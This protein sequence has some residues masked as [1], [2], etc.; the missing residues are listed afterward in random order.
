MLVGCVAGLPVQTETPSEHFDTDYVETH[1]GSTKEEVLQKLGAPDAIF[2]AK[3][4]TYYVYEAAGD[5][6]GVFGLVVVVPPFF[7]PFWTPK[8][9]GEALHCLGLVFDDKGYLQDYLTET[10]PEAAGVGF[11]PG[12]G[13]PVEVF[14]TEEV[15]G[16]VKTLWTYEERQSLELVYPRNMSEEAKWFCPQADDGIADSQ[17]RIGDLLYYGYGERRSGDLV[18]AY[19]W[20]SLSA[21]GNNSVAQMRLAAV[22]KELTHEDL[23]E[24][25]QRLD[26]W[27]PRHGQCMKD[28][29]EAGLL[30][31]AEQQY[32]RYVALSPNDPTRLPYL[33]RAADGGHPNAQIE[34]GR[35]FAQGI[36]GLT[37]DLRRAYVWYSLAN[38]SFPDLV[39]LQSVI[40][41]MSPEQIAEAEQMLVS[42]KPGQ[43]ARELLGAGESLE[44]E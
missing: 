34:V 16:C 18:G 14:S 10:A 30:D 4:R 19:V 26:A 6:R 1:V 27:K 31:G 24:A 9:E 35:H 3:G 23:R 44:A 22:E 41:Q 28:L 21:M 38:R 17:R 15:T 5:F 40:K 42:W 39:Q 2:G 8:A 37:P 36:G 29:L 20:Y 13:P 12:I 43:C 32:R 25:R 33:C 7:I 11:F